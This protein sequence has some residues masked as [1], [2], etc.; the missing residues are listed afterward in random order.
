MRRR[1]YSEFVAPDI[2]RSAGLLRALASRSIQLVVAVTPDSAA[3]CPGVIGACR[4]HGVEVAIW[5]MLEPADGRWANAENADRFSSFA[6]E[7]ASDLETEDALPDE[8]V[9]DLE[10]PYWFK[11]RPLR[12]LVKAQKLNVGSATDRFRMLLAELAAL[13]LT[14]SA[15]V[16]PTVA[17]G[18]QHVGR[19]WQH[20][21]G[22]PVSGL[23][24]DHVSI[25]VYTSLIEGY[26][27][28]WLGRADTTALLWQSARAVRKACGDRAGISLG[29]IGTG[30]FGDEG[31]Y[32]GPAQLAEDV[33]I[34]RA[35]GVTDLALFNLGGALARPPLDAWLDPMVD[36]RPLAAVPTNTLRA[37]SVWRL[38]SLAGHVGSWLH[39]NR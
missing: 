11:E 8:V 16:A 30:V 13:G 32:R 2:L 19:G 9:I 26:S 28:G 17:M 31:T 7:L 22:T 21:I 38:A 10:P 1:I 24:F 4:E 3:T 35:A 39:R 23:P 20:L 25:M 36:D 12:G 34:A 5:P 6:V 29:C 14:V 27:R 33:A 15:V 18:P 37:A